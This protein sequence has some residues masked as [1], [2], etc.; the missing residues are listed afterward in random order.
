MI[1]ITSASNPRIKQAVA[2]R[3]RRE[4]ENRG[5]FLVDGLREIERAMRAGFAIRQWFLPETTSEI[6]REKVAGLRGS[7]ADLFE[8]ASSAFDKLAYGERTTAIVAV[9]EVKKKALGD[10]ELGARPL[11]GIVE[12]VE[13]PG[14]LGAILRTADAA[15]VTAIVV[16]DPT[17]DLY[18]PNVIRASAGAIFSVPTVACSGTEIR[19]WLLKKGWK[20]YTTSANGALRYDQAGFQTACAIVF[21]SEAHGLSEIWKGNDFTSIHIPMRGAVDSLN[22]S[23]TAAVLFYEALRQRS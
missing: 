14:N 20:A 17:T 7:Q 2:L 10:L 5:E 8:V 9:A 15:G 11:V 6:D 3:E 1:R 19:D 13:K 16:A 21:G 18:N 12:G 22:L 23:V 4:R